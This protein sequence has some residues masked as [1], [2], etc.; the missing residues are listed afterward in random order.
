MSLTELYSQHKLKA[1][2]SWKISMKSILVT[3]IEWGK[4]AAHATRSY[5]D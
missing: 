4:P 5:I 1:H 2:L 3:N